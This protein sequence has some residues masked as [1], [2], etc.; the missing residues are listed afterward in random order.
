[1]HK[2]PFS[3]TADLDFLYASDH[4]QRVFEET[5][6]AIQ[7]RDGLICVVG[8]SGTGK[9]ILCRRLLQELNGDFNVVLVNTPPR[10]P[11]DITETLDTAFRDMEGDSK[12]PLA[13]FDE[14]QHLDFRCLDHVKF[15][16]NLDRNAEKLLQIV[17]VGQPELAAKLGHKRFQQLEQRIGAKLKVGPLKKKEVLPY[18]THRLTVAGL[19]DEIRFTGFAARY[20]HRKAAGVPR[21]INR[22]ANLAVEQAGQRGGKIG[23]AQVR[24]SFLKVAATRENWITPKKPAF[25]LGRLSA[26]VLLLVLS[27]LALLYYNPE[28]RALVV[29]EPADKSRSQPAASR[30]VIKTGTF[31]VRDQAEELRGQLGKQGFPSAVVE[32]QFGDGWTLYQVRLAG[33]YSKDESDTI[34]DLLR[35]IGVKSVDAVEM[36]P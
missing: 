7:R 36:K 15:L 21:L 10:T 27:L 35:T 19:A 16:T 2:R 24:Q 17:L 5:L 23:V 22:V 6:A 30:F 11:Q 14:A 31:L 4:H 18:L 29:A 9:T 34:I 12:I 3:L 13:V 1:M 8:D 20:L 32:K 33:Q 25:R 26:L 28:W